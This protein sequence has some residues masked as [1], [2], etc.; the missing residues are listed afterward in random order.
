MPIFCEKKKPPRFPFS[1]LHIVQ[2]FPSLLGLPPPPTL[3]HRL[4]PQTPSPTLP[5]RTIHKKGLYKWGYALSNLKLEQENQC[6]HIKEYIYNPP[7]SLF[8]HLSLW[9][10]SFMEGHKLKSDKKESFTAPFCCFFTSTTT[11]CVIFLY[12]A[13]RWPF[14]FHHPSGPY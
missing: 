6:N 4:H 12:C 13:P 14:F 5:S 2:R 7:A 10:M 1:L 3:S 11:Y 9:W 8:S